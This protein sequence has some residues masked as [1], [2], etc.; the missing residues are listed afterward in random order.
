MPWLFYFVLNGQLCALIEQCRPPKSALVTSSETKLLLHQFRGSD[1][2]D[3]RSRTRH[4][5]VEL[6]D[7]S[8]RRSEGQNRSKTK[9]MIDETS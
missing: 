7:C 4:D 8:N 5:A 3:C 2:M 1:V 6:F 9:I